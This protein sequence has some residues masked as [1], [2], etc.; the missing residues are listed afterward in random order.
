MAMMKNGNERN[1]AMK[2]NVGRGT[3]VAVSTLE[4]ASKVCRK[5]LKRTGLGSRAWDGGEVKDEAGK[6]VAWV[7]FNGKVWATSPRNWTPEDR[8]VF[9]PF[10]E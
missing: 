4:E 9:S 2:V 8:P 1:E 6:A 3:M 10:A 5:Y 7:S